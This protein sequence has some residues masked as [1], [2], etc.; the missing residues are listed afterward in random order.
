[1]KATVHHRDTEAGRKRERKEHCFL[2]LV[3]NP[4]SYAKRHKIIG[5]VLKTKLCVSVSLWLI[6]SSGFR[7]CS[8]VGSNSDTVGWMCMAREITV[9]G[10]LAYITSRIV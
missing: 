9:Y 2:P 10:A 1:M 5:L 4:Q 3:A 6:H 8:I 7:S